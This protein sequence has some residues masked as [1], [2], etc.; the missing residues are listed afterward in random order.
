MDKNRKKEL[1]EQYKRTKPRMGVLIIRHKTGDKCYVQAANDLRAGMNGALARLNGGMH[2]N[3]ELQ[4]E[5]RETGADSFAV[6][7]LEELPYDEDEAKTDYTGELA[8]LQMIWEE[9]LTREGL[10]LYKKKL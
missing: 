1:L 7:I 9:K 10:H 8:L 3:R 5:W 2:I 6:E 4:K